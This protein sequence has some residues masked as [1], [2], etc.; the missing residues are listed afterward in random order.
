M[1]RAKTEMMEAEER[2]WRSL[3]THVCVDCVEDE[4][5]KSLIKD[6]VVEDVCD[7]CGRQESE[8]IAAPTEVIQEPIGSA[9]RYFFTDPTSA[10]VPW[11][12]G[13]P[14]VD[15]VG[16]IEVLGTLSIDCHE[17]LFNEIEGAFVNS[18]WVP[19]AGG[20][21]VSSHPHEDL[22]Y[23]WDKFVNSV[24]HEVRY[25]FTKKA[26]G[27]HDEFSPAE[28][29]EKIGSIAVE[30]RL[31]GTLP[32]DM[33]L[34]RVRERQVDADWDIDE[35]SMGPPPAEKATAGR[36]NPAGISYFYLAQELETA[37]A[38]VLS[39]PPC[40]AAC[41]TFSIRWEL[42]VLDLCRIPPL[43]SI[44]DDQQRDL[45]EGLLFI[46]EFV[47][48][49]SQ[50]VRKDGTEHVEYVP[51]QVVSEYFAKVFRTANGEPIHGMVYPSAVRPGGQ[52]VVMFPPADPSD[53]F[54]HLLKFQ[55]GDTLSCATWAD[56]V[57]II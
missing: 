16:T 37:C 45:R 43:P 19:T 13:S 10:G 1:G 25:F 42:K 34:Y 30:A 17:D 22:S 46:E 28:L 5:L 2:G 36:M 41:G 54:A 40:E 26:T 24:K 29:L 15:T 31:I 53:H 50:P 20:N 3:D 14:V 38:E 27:P 56:F 33:R 35:I 32:V 21:W 55:I 8:P 18:E 57:K 9:V 23:S 48:S 52:N 4:F 39:G 6:N 12:E 51:S 11:E 44:F 47:A 49:I 7:Y